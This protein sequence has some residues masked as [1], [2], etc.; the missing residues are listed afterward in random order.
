MQ[1]APSA[2]G[3]HRVRGGAG[4]GL[5]GGEGC[6]EARTWGES[7]LELGTGRSFCGAQVAELHASPS[8]CEHRRRDLLGT[9]EH[10]G[11]PRRCSRKLLCMLPGTSR[12]WRGMVSVTMASLQCGRT[13]RQ[14]TQT[15]PSSLALERA[16]AL[17]PQLR[18]A[19]ALPPTCWCRRPCSKISTAAVRCSSC[20]CRCSSRR[21]TIRGQSCRCT[22]GW[23]QEHR[24]SCT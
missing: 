16:L 22:W 17:Q 8:V 21:R 5:G 10:S 19:K 20:R 14:E 12:I 18:T 4:G 3:L 23:C 7:C 1:Q 11:A 2:G 13:A 15:A 24:G 9:R 6:A